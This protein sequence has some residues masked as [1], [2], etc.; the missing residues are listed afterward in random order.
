ML[1]PRSLLM[2][3]LYVGGG[4]FLGSV[5]FGTLF[6]AVAVWNTSMW[7]GVLLAIVAMNGLAGFVYLFIQHLRWTSREIEKERR[8]FE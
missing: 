5:G 4:M 6:A 3:V 2:G 7:L 1:K 8:S